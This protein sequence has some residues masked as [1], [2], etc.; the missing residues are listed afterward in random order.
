M[1][2]LR[3]L[4][5]GML[6]DVVAARLSADLVSQDLSEEYGQDPV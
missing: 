1:A 4:V 5:G 6:G 2:Q 3:D